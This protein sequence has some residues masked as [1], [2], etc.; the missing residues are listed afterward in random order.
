MVLSRSRPQLC[1]VK[2]LSKPQ[3]KQKKHVKELFYLSV[4]FQQFS[5]LFYKMLFMH[6]KVHLVLLSLIFCFL[7]PLFAFYRNFKRWN[8]N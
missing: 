3:F 4:Q 6:E 8:D 2:T 7:N 5:S 1:E